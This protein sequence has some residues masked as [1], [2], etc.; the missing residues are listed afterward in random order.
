MPSSVGSGDRTSHDSYR[1][2]KCDVF[3]FVTDR[4]PAVCCIGSTQWSKNGFFAPQRRH[5]A[6]INVNFDMESE[7]VQNPH[8]LDKII[9]TRNSASQ[10]GRAM[11]RVI[12]YFAKS[13]KVIVHSKLTALST[14]R[15]TPY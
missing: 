1:Q 6:P 12:E 10:R 11:L 3:F 8:Q 9:I 4:L 5:I 7:P 2:I 14:A 15:I 13:L